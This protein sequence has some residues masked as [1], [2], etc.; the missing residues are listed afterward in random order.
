MKNV[1][2]EEA[3]RI[4]EIAGSFGRFEFV[5]ERLMDAFSAVCG[6]SPAYVFMLIEAMADAAV[7]QGASKKP[8]LFFAVRSMEAQKWYWKQE[9]IRGNRGHG[10]FS[11]RKY[12]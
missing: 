10:M 3:G 12:H 9:S 7:A 6:C 4:A 2:E 8:V 11:G 5:P 1:T